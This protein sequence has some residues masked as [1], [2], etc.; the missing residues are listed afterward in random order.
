MTAKELIKGYKNTFKAIQEK[1]H[2]LEHTKSLS[3]YKEKELYHLKNEQNTIHMFIIHLEMMDNKNRVINIGENY[4][5]YRRFDY[6][7]APSKLFHLG[8]IIIKKF[9]PSI[10]KEYQLKSNAEIG[11]ILQVH[12]PD[13]GDEFRTDMFGN[14]SLFVSCEE[15]LTFATLKEIKKYRPELLGDIIKA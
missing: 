13:G 1:I 8:D 12:N 14:G 4:N 10:V 15:T 11:V 9:S 3:E 5:K 7:S 2:I 6:D